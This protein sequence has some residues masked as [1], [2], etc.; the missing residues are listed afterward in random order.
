MIMIGIICELPEQQLYKSFK[1]CFKTD[2]NASICNNFNSYLT[3]TIIVIYLPYNANRS[4]WKT[5]AVFVD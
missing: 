4:W 5:F 3:V 1:N 2:V